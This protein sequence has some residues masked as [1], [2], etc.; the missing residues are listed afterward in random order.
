MPSDFRTVPRFFMMT[1]LPATVGGAEAN[2][3]DLSVR[4]AR[5]QVTQ[6]FVIGA[7]LPFVLEAASGAVTAEATVSWCRMAA[8]ALDDLESDRYL[9]GV[10]FD[11]EVPGIRE[12]IDDLMRRELAMRIED[13]RCSERYSIT[14]QITGSFDL[15]APVR[16]LDLSI[17]G[18]RIITDRMVLPGTTGALRFRVDRKNVDFIAHMVWC[19]PA[20]RRG[21]FEV[22]LKIDGEE[23]LLRQIIAHLCTHNQA[24]IDLNSLR[25]KFDPMRGEQAPGL[26]ALV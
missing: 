24:R 26:L 8:L 15:H 23:P 17:G 11:R 5:V 22:G 25:R 6:P 4:G 19:R 10:M 2:V 16:L 20:E 21:G 13:A 1:A 9:C 18:A 7:M 14:A 12:V 3:V